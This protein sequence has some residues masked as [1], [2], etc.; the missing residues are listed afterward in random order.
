M[1]ALWKF[2]GLRGAIALG[3]AIAL[4]VA[5]LRADAISAERDL[6]HDRLTDAVQARDAER[7][8]HQQTKKRYRSAQAEAEAL[9]RARLA[10]VKAEQQEIT[11]EVV[12]VYRLRLAD[13]R[14]RAEQLRVQLG[15]AG[16][17]PAGSP[18]GEYLS[19]TGTAA[20]GIDGAAP[21]PGLSLYERLVATEQA[22]QLD[23]LISWVERQAQ[24]ET[25]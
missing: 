25:D 3:L 17:H 12:A 19:G 20:A 6:A 23:A 4:A 5:V 1:T 24:V 22:I 11:D 16:E 10:R 2:L 13:A 15:R 9:E 7:A 14:A 21:D 18:G 8:A